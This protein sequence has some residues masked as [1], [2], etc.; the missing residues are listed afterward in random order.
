MV[1]KNLDGV[2]KIIFT[3]SSMGL[4]GPFKLYGLMPSY[5]HCAYEVVVDIVL[6]SRASGRHSKNYLQFKTIRKL[7]IAY[8]HFERI[9]LVQACNRLVVDGRGGEMKDINSLATSS[10]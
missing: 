7:R 8:G 5:D 1:C 6:A 9:S 4:S 2:R 3:S 10:I